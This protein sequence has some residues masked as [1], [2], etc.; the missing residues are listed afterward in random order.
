MIKKSNPVSMVDM[1]IM[2]NVFGN[3]QIAMSEYL[4]SFIEI[5]SELLNNAN[6][7]ISEKNKIAAMD[8]FHQLKGPVGSIGF[9]KMYTLCEEAEK[10]ITQSNWD[11]ADQ[12]CCDMKKV[13]KKL[14]IEL[15][16]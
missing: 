13:L 11:S 2:Y 4:E 6:R 15:Q 12:L 7:A 1:D 14:A 16:K 9:K 10:K 5:T 8:Y 3:N